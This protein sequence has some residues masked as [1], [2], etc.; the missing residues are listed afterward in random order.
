MEE[1]AR[2]IREHVLRMTHRAKCSH[3]GSCLSIAD[4]LAVLYSGVLNVKPEQPDWEK[5]D[6]FILSKGHACAAVYAVLAECGFFPLEWLDGFYQS[7]SL[8]SG[9]ISHQVPGVEASTGS[10]GQGLSIGCGMALATKQKVFV[11]LGDGDCNEGSTWEAVMFARQH[12]LANLVAIVDY[13]KIQALGKTKD[14]LDLVSLR[15][16]W[17]AFGWNTIEVDGHDLLDLVDGLQVK[18]DI[19]PHCIIAHTIKGK[20]VSWM[21]NRV[22]W[23]YKHPNDE[24]LESALKE[25]NRGN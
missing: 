15:A 22:E 18:V 21:E 8:L 20:G 17:L 23:H 19:Q 4:I 1:L 5:R 6:R 25:L 7:G 11:L 14:V 10:L 3:V 16:K 13:N 2:K 24:E 12:C 9:H